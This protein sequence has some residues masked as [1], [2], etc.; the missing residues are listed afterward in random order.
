MKTEI[1]RLD[2]N[3]IRLLEWHL[4][5]FLIFLLFSITRF[6]LRARGLNTAPVGISVLIFSV[7][8]VIIVGLSTSGLAIINR[9][10]KQ[11]PSLGEALNNEYVQSIELKS[12][13]AAFIG[14]VASSVFFAFVSFFYP[15]HDPVLVALNS[16]VT[17]AGAYHLNFYLSYKLS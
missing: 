13:R 3:R 1:E 6:F 10:I 5:G 8:G 2:R 4:A 17:G 7:V 12:W 9:R 15:I 16:I 11:E 14:S